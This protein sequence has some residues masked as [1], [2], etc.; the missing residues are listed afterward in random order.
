[1]STTDPSTTLIRPLEDRD[2]P[3]VL[4]IHNDA[5]ANTTAIWDDAPS[6]LEGRRT[7]AHDRRAAGLP[8]LAAEVE[9][10]C[11]GY[12]SYGPWRP[13]IGYRFTAEVSVYVDGAWR[14]KGLASR[15]LAEL[16]RLARQSDVHV[17]VG[18]IEASNAASL[19]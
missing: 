15:L 9:G 6:D 4:A 5:V 19:A 13:R 11:R 18:G 3:A 2:L 8:V 1:M 17:L 10:A 16:E 7:W 12:A 14:G